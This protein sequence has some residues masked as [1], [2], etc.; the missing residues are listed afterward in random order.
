MF[1]TLKISHTANN[2]WIEDQ[3]EVLPTGFHCDINLRHQVSNDRLLKRI[4]KTAAQ[5]CTRN[6]FK[7]ET[8]RK[9]DF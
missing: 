6:L 8:D 3:S 5:R 7:L 1:L 9:T 2:F 4:I